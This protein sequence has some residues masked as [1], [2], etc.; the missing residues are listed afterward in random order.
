M[1]PIILEKPEK[2]AK[3]R[4]DDIFAEYLSNPELI[5]DIWNKTTEQKYLYWDKFRFNDPILGHSITESWYLVRQ[6][7]RNYSQPIP[8][9]NTDGYPYSL[10]IT[11]EIKTKLD[12]IDYSLKESEKSWSSYDLT[13]WQKKAKLALIEESITSSQIEGANTSRDHALKMITTQISPK[14]RDEQMIKNNYQVMQDIAENYSKEKLSI[15]TIRELQAE[16]TH[17]T[18]DD[19]FIPG[20]FRTDEDKIVVTFNNK[21]SYKTPPME[22]VSH[23]LER[24]IKFANDNSKYH[25]IVKAIMLHFWFAY[26]HP[27]PD[28][29][30]RTARAL[31]YWSLYRDGYKGI[32]YLSVSSII[33]RS[34]K[35]YALAY[36][37]SEQDNYD[38]TYFLNYNLTK[39]ITA[40]NEFTEYLEKNY[41]DTK[42]Y[43][44]FLNHKH[45]ELNV[46]QIDIMVYLKEKN[47]S[48]TMKECMEIYDVS[49][50]T[51]YNDLDKLKSLGLIVGSEK[52]GYKKSNLKP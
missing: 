50:R 7:R 15:S 23:E 22:F 16:L 12:F 1:E 31:F 33:K 45:P 47:H 6:L 27:F 43:K 25:P 2:L 49:R 32:A 48:T 28:G 39:I 36:L 51:A 35:N 20:E 42:R 10:F 41:E 40:I 46:R 3:S 9:Y 30:G 24:F 11:K 34:Q 5:K 19:G 13:D 37:Y 52:Q 44:H 17:D 8:V 21:I 26:L 29:N 38:F 4:I 18:L 14:T